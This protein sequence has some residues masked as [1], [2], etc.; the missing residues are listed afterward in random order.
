M[1]ARAASARCLIPTRPGPTATSTIVYGDKLPF[2]ATGPINL[3]PPAVQAWGEDMTYLATDTVPV[4]AAAVFS[5]DHVPAATPTSADWPYATLTYM[6]VNGRPVNTATYGDGGWQVSSTQYDAYGNDVWSITPANLAQAITPISGVTDPA[7][8][9]MPTGWRAPTALA[10]LKTYNPDDPSELIETLGPT[11][12]ITVNNN[13]TQTL[14]D[15]RQYVGYTYDQGEPSTGAPFRLVTTTM[16]MAQSVSGT[17]NYDTVYTYTGYAAVDPNDVTGWVLHKPTT[18]LQQLADLSVLTTTTRYNSVGHVIE[19]RLPMG[20]ANGAG[21][22]DDAYST[23]TT[24]YTPGT[25]GSCVSNAL[26]GLLCSTGP[27]AQPTTGKPLPVTT[28]TYNM[29]DEPLVV[30]ETAGSVVRT[31]HVDL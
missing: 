24:Y 2:D 6:D 20:A 3:T 26:A 8:S 11:H 16:Q 22:G 9:A 17:P 19:S 4:T 5:P 18:V 1:T 31:D 13:G 12:P 27:A 28:T 25:G 21:D 30:T 10:T 15:G 7:V 23:D 29:Y 14:I